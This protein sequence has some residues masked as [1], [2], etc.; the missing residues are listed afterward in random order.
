[1]PKD[2]LGIGLLGKIDDDCDVSEAPIS[3]FGKILYVGV[4]Y[5]SSMSTKSSIYEYRCDTGAT[6]TKMRLLK[7][8]DCDAKHQ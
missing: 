5:W 3:N 8:Q 4:P 7:Y 1:M 2:Q 6:A